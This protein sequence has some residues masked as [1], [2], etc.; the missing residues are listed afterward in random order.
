METIKKQ[1]GERIKLLREKMQLSQKDFAELIGMK[2]QYLSNVEKGLNGITIEKLIE[3]CNK[4]G[5][6]SDYIIFGKNSI[7]AYQIQENFSKYTN[8][9]LI[10]AFDIIKNTI[11]L[12]K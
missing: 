7:S 11:I 6:S 8:E 1:I 9:E 10:T 12:Y 2:N 4:T 5:I 3:I